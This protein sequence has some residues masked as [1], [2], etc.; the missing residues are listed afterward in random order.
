MIKIRRFIAAFR[1]ALLFLAAGLA[2]A[3]AASAVSDQTIAAV[4]PQGTLTY[5]VFRDGER[6]GTHTV[7]FER[8]G[9]ELT[10]RSDTSF[11]FTRLFV[12]GFTFIHQA[13]EVWQDGALKEFTSFTDDDGKKREVHAQRAGEHLLVTASGQTRELPGSLIPAS[14]WHPDTIEQHQLLDPIKGRLREVSVQ[15]RGREPVALAGHAVAAHHYALRGGLVRDIW[16]DE[17]G[18]VVK[19]AFQASDGSDITMLLQ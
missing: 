7:I 16:Y 15:D 13:V 19:V 1:L 18:T 14:L 11:D 12:L 8:M 3:G 9:D 5:G 4:A 6:I 10:V 17:D 2:P